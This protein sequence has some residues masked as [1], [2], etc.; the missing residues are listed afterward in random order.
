MAFRCD[1]ELIE[2]LRLRADNRAVLDL[3]ESSSAHGDLG[4]VLFDYAKATG[5]LRVVPLASTDFPAL[6]ATPRDDDV[7]VAA[8][9]GMQSLLL[10]VGDE[11]PD[12]A[13]LG[14]EP[15]PEA[16]PGWWRVN[17]FDA[18]VSRA[19]TAIELQRWFG[20]ARNQ[21]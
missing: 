1:D 4:E 3:V 9:T 17:P 2:Q 16:G 5:A 10:R 6:V 12:G 8:A 19:N 11:P 21:R 15:V 14:H 20:A 7:I 18:E 13:R